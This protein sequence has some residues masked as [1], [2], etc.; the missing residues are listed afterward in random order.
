MRF[1]DAFTL[2][3]PAQGFPVPSFK[4]V[5]HKVFIENTF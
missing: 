2:L 4:Y 1:G 3:C 5:F